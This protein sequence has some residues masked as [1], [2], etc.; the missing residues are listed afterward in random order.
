MWPEKGGWRPANT[1]SHDRSRFDRICQR[2]R[3]AE[4]QTGRV[5]TADAPAGHFMRAVNGGSPFFRAIGHNGLARP[6]LE[7]AFLPKPKP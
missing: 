7:F 1:G 3:R 4:S 2:L 5:F 6:A